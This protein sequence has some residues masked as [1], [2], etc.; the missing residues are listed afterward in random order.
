MSCPRDRG[1]LRRHRLAHA[2]GFPSEALLAST[3]NR[4]DP[5]WCGPGCVSRANGCV[6]CVCHLT[7]AFARVGGVGLLRRGRGA[8]SS[9]GTATGFAAT[10]DLFVGPKTGGLAQRILGSTGRFLTRRG[11]PGRQRCRTRRPT[12][13]RPAL[14]ASA[15]ECKV[16][17]LLAGRSARVLKQ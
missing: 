5:D 8:G 17:A 4:S 13:G 14:L 6:L 10:G 11:R 16:P 1:R 9:Q 7:R 2:P 3:A 12:A 15:Y